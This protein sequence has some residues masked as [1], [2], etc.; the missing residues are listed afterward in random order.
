MILNELLTYATSYRSNNAIE[1]IKKLM[2]DFY[3]SDE[4]LTAKK[5][6]W[7][8]YG[9]F[10]ENFTDR[11]TTDNRTAEDANLNDILIALINLD[12]KNVTTEFVAKDLH[13]VP[14]RAPE[15]LN[16]FSLSVAYMHHFRFYLKS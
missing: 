16:P 11:R 13:R 3:T 2:L 1:N 7:D 8:V 5:L 15:E 10:L 6:L 14:K 9:N 4:I 12:A